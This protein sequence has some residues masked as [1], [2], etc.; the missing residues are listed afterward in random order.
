M[1]ILFQGDSIT[2]VGRSRDYDPHMGAGYPTMLAGMLGME[3]PGRVECLNRGISGNRVVDLYARWRMDGVNLRP[4]VI[5]ILIGINDVWHEIGNKNGVEA[6]RFFTVYDML[7]DYS[8]RCLPD[9]KLIVL[10]PFV[11]LGEATKDAYDVFERETALR[12]MAAKA[13]AEK[14]GALFVPLQSAFDEAAKRAPM[15]FWLVDGVHPTQAGHMLI[16]TE[17]F[18]AFQNAA[19]L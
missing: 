15:D 19:W 6:D 14:H 7:M 4:D 1:K 17:W 8:K 5:S 13:V 11:A 12:A 16:A 18:K 2:D 10:E 9:V 3:Y